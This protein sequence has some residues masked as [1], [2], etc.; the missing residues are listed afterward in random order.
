MQLDAMRRISAEVR[1]DWRAVARVFSRPTRRLR[2]EV[3]GRVRHVPIHGL[4]G[5]DAD[6]VAEGVREYLADPS[7]HAETAQRL[8][9]SIESVTGG[10]VGDGVAGRHFHDGWRGTTI[11]FA[12][13][14]SDRTIAHELGHAIASTHGYWMPADATDEADSYEGELP[15]WRFNADD[16][17]AHLLRRNATLATVAEA[18]PGGSG[19]VLSRWRNAVPGYESIRAHGLDP[20]CDISEQRWFDGVP[21]AGDYVR[22][23]EPDGTRFYGR[24]VDAQQPLRVRLDGGDISLFDLDG[25]VI[26]DGVVRGFDPEPPT[27]GH[28]AT[29]ER[30]IA[31]ANKA[32]YRMAVER[33]V[34][35]QPTV[36]HTPYSATNAHET[37]AKTHEL[38]QTGSGVDERAVRFEDSFPGLYGAYT[39]LFEASAAAVAPPTVE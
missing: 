2:F 30:L 34:G 17:A 28:A 7:E 4:E 39:A 27:D 3:G 13:Q 38:L 8:L 9:A 22:V 5:D 33:C 14:P 31:E 35:M 32:W 29:I 26:V 10:T 12:P 20:S 21:T 16:P 18:L 11:R 6:A 19:R 15:D 24:V 36:I 23:R 25:G 37:L 1:R